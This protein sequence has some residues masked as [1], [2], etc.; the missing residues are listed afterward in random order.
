MNIICLILR[1]LFSMPV[2]IISY[3]VFAITTGMYISCPFRSLT[4]LRCPGCGVTH[5]VLNLIRGRFFAAFSC[6][7]IVFVLLVYSIVIWSLAR[8]R[9]LKLQHRFLHIID[10]LLS[11]HYEH[12]YIL[13]LIIV[14]W[15]ILRNILGI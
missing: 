15:G 14:I 3:F 10:R 2:V 7:P 12:R 9:Q 13:C 8:I 4:G 11:L 1:K 5:L 6:N